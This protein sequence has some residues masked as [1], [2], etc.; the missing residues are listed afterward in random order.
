MNEFFSFLLQVNNADLDMSIEEISNDET[1][2]PNLPKLNKENESTTFND[3]D[4]IIMS[5]EDYARLKIIKHSLNKCRL[6]HDEYCM[7][8]LLHQQVKCVFCG[9]TCRTIMCEMRHVDQHC[10]KK[11]IY[12]LSIDFFMD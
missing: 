2:P 8:L 3:P 12:N 10:A 4:E 9:E 11:E 7:P 1:F 6:C 5:D